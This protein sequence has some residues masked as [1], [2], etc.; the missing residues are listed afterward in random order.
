MMK[1]KLFYSQL[2]GLL[3]ILLL[4]LIYVPKYNKSIPD[5]LQKNVQSKLENNHLPW[6]AVQ[7]KDRD[8]TLS[9][10]APDM[11]TH[12][13]AI[14]IAESVFGVRNV[15]DKI[16]PNIITPYIFHVE[17]NKKEI[18]L[19]GYM[20]SKKSKKELLTLLAQHYNNKTII[21][22]VKIGAGSPKAWSRLIYTLIKEI[23][24]SNF[25]SFHIVDKEVQLSGKVATEKIKKSI[26]K[27]ILAFEENNFTILEHLVAMDRPLIICQ[28]KFNTLLSQEKIEFASGKSEIKAKSSH[29]IEELSYVASLCPQVTIKISGYTDN[30]GDNETNKRL[31][32]ARAKAVVAKLFQSGVD[33]ERILP[34]GKGEENPIADNNTSE[35]QAKN[36]RIE[37]QVI[38][39]KER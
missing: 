7:V 29:L 32:L 16:T 39:K 5:K 1:S 8:V 4:L 27:K 14:K 19:E 23:S 36:R 37:F 31:S 21:D 13:K 15:H 25:S 35:G 30:I 3:L 18:I 2:F 38:I 22:K 12:H 20:P 17:L 6:T 10:I 34:I 33:L 26:S 28:E 24:I 11:N 9:G